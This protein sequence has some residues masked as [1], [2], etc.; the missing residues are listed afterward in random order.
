MAYSQDEINNIFDAICL[1]I[2]EGESLRSVLRDD[3]MPSSRTFFKWIHEDDIKVKQYARSTSE[4]ADAMFE[5]MLEICD[6]VGGDM[7]TLPD[8]REVVD[9]AVIARDRLRVDTRKWAAAKMNPKKYGDKVET[10]HS[11]E[12]K[13]NEPKV[14]LVVDG[15]TINLK[16]D[17]KKK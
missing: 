7:V 3:N 16:E 4:R 1:R 8:G 15:K 13:G 14:N 12:I 2:E 10:I 5:D 11:G 6:N 17:S 9:N